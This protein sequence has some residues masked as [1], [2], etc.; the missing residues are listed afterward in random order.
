MVIKEI[1]KIDSIGLVT[2]VGIFSSKRKADVPRIR[3]ESIAAGFGVMIIQ[4][5]NFSESQNGFKSQQI[6]RIWAP[7]MAATTRA[8]GPS[9]EQ[10]LT[11]YKSNIGVLFPQVADA[12]EQEIRDKNENLYDPIPPQWSAKLMSLKNQV[13]EQGY[14]SALKQGQ[15]SGSINKDL[16]MKI[17]IAVFEEFSVECGIT[18]KKEDATFIQLLS[19]A[20]AQHFDDLW[21][22]LPLY[23]LD[24]SHI[25]M[26]I[27]S[28]VIATSLVLYRLNGSISS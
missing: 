27:G 20:G 4:I 19:M 1:N 21:E 25:F 10:I 22:N 3:P 16:Q 8:A 9:T 15:N 7:V 28:M 12:I 14:K 18:L 11:S 2:E 13:L 17:L 23:G 26:E 5:L 24:N 6:R